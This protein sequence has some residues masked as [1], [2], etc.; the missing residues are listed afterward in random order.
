MCLERIKGRN[1]KPEYRQ[2]I[3]EI[4]AKRKRGIEGYRVKEIFFFCTIGEVTACLHAHEND[5][6]EE[7]LVMLKR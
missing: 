2:L 3:K 7:K 1:W 5:S 4:C 6:I